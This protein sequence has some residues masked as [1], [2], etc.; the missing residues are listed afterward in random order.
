V[1]FQVRASDSDKIVI[2]ITER[3]SVHSEVEIAVVH[4]LKIA[5]LRG[6]GSIQ[7]RNQLNKRFAL[8]T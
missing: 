8:I 6:N 3:D 2:R 7:Q 1:R 4:G 5:S